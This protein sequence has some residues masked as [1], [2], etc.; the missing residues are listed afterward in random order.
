MRRLAGREGRCV[1]GAD[2]PVT[3]YGLGD[4]VDN[5]GELSIHSSG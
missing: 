1:T 5:I 2:V 3:E 4:G